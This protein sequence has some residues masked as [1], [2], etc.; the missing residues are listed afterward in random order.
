MHTS[1]FLKTLAGTITIVAILTISCRELIAGDPV[2]R[3]RASV[4]VT[5]DA[6]GVREW[7]DPVS[8]IKATVGAGLP[9]PTVLTSVVNGKA[10]LSFAGNAFLTVNNT[11]CFK[12]SYSIYVVLKHNGVAGSNNIVSG[13]QHALWLA[14]TTFPHVLHN[15]DFAQQSVSNVALNGWCVLRVMF[16]AATGR[17]KIAVNNAEGAS[18]IVPPTNDPT[19][20][21]G[22]FAASNFYN[23]E[24]AEVVYYHGVLSDGDRIV[25]DDRLHT[26]YAIARAADP[27]PPVVIFSVAPKRLQ[28][29]PI[30]DSIRIDGF[31]VEPAVLSVDLTLDSNGIVIDR[32]SWNVASDGPSFVY[33]RAIPIPGTSQFRVVVTASRSGKR[34]TVLKSDSITNGVVIAIS[35]QSNSVFGDPLGTQAALARTFGG[36]FSAS[37]ADTAWSLSNPRLYG[38]GSTVG[39]AGMYLQN[40]LIA[41]NMPSAVINGGVGGTTIQQHLPSAGFTESLTTIHGSWSYRRR[42][43]QVNKYINWI[44]WYQG[45]SNSGQDDYATMF[46]SVYKQWHKEMP[47]LQHIIVVQIRPGCGGTEHALLREKQRVLQ[48]KYTD[49][50]VIAA[51]G[52]PEHDGCHY[53]SNGYISLG[54]ILAHHMDS[55]GY[56]GNGPLNTAW[57]SPDIASATFEN[58]T[59]TLVRLRFKGYGNS[60]PSLN[61]TPEITIGGT[62]RTHH[63]A[64]FGNSDESVRPIRVDVIG[65]EVLL[66]FSKA[67]TKVSYIPSNAYAGTAVVYQGPWL[68]NAS[69]VGALTFHDYPVSVLSGVDD[70]QL[71]NM[72]SIRR[73]VD[74]GELIQLLNPFEGIVRIV[75]LRGSEVHTTSTSNGAFVVPPLAAAPYIVSAGD[76]RMIILV[77]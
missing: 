20:L 62:V 30:G 12:G 23:G 76:T 63:Q 52:L 59:K 36:N 11:E 65:D 38:G 24:I 57:S 37:P 64:F 45:E 6:N 28:L 47:N 46:D 10:A 42:I 72:S 18:T 27:P 56:T 51:A 19:F 1:P 53:G 8:G 41:Q 69:G 13:N 70:A 73:M 77:R 22:A 71:S 54:K 55:G 32:R 34:D 74:V 14:N 66:T 58:E 4:G 61:M 17:A 60:I 7:L 3:L 2:V 25:E 67:V 31:V 48:Q 9:Q 33:T 5:V 75:D 39:A 15:S 44:I 40:H 29:I 16:D 35:G 50:T 49:V 21:V 26:F 43:A 68:T